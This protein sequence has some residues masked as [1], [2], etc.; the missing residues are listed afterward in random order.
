MKINGKVLILKEYIQAKF[1]LKRF[2]NKEKL[3]EWQN[4]KIQKKYI[5]LSKKLD[6]FKECRKKPIVNWKDLPIIN[7]KIMMDNFKKMNIKKITKSQAYKIALDA[8]KNINSNKTQGNLTV[9]LSSGTSGNRGIFL[10]SPEERC[11]WAGNILAKVLPDKIWKRYKVALFLR[12]NNN[13]YTTV[14]NN[15][16]SLEFF[17]IFDNLQYLIEKLNKFQPDILLAP[18][19]MLRLLVNKEKLRIKPIKVISIAEV[20]DKLDEEIISFKFKQKI[21][22]IYQATEGFIATSCEK[23]TLH[24]NEDLIFMEKEFLDKKRFVPIITDFHRTT[25]PIFRY[26]L[27]DIL[28]EKKDKCPCGSIYTAIDK[29]EGRCDDI[30]YFK[31][32]NSYNN[33]PIFPDFISR[34]IIRVSDTISEYKVIQ[35]K[36]DFVEVQLK[37]TNNILRDE[38]Q[39]KVKNSLI[40]LLKK[41]KNLIT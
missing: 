33:I 15:L 6:Y 22:Q 29:I 21:H 38:I 18:P 36:I 34:S 28:T 16:I 17:N 32:L 39:Y 27:N 10:I 5:E 8:E 14:N 30:F 4:K 40:N 12:V 3:R 9:G 41:K 24:L 13:L 2:K 37:Y 35:K 20:L 7:K 1:L 31:S 26:R 19:S 11:K 25:Q 23:G